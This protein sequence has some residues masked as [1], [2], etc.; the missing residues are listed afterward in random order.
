MSYFLNWTLL[1]WNLIFFYTKR[2]M[3][4]WQTYVNK[5][6][7]QHF[8]I[9]FNI[10]DGIQDAKYTFLVRN[11]WYQNIFNLVFFCEVFKSIVSY[12]YHMALQWLKFWRIAVFVLIKKQLAVLKLNYCWTLCVCCSHAIFK[13]FMLYKFYTV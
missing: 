8:A 12:D 6:C 1:Y 7:C 10:V 4:C 11:V 13:C 9:F 5:V 2:N 3:T